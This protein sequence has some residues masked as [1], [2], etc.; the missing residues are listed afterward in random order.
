MQ[1]EKILIQHKKNNKK[2]NKI[3]MLNIK[4]IICKYVYTLTVKLK[5]KVRNCSKYKYIAYV[6]DAT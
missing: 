3:K 5:W 1:E 4:E 2:W 6:V